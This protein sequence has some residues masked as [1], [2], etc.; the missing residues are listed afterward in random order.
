MP[1]ALAL[2]TLSAALAFEPAPKDLS[3]ETPQKD[4]SEDQLPAPEGPQELPEPDLE[5]ERPAAATASTAEPPVSERAHFVFANYYGLTV[6]VSPLPSFDQVLFLGR[7]FASKA[8]GARRLALGYSLTLS[9]GGADRYTSGIIATRHHITAKLYGGRRERLM[10][11]IG[12]GLALH[13]IIAPSVAEAEARIGYLF[14]GRLQRRRAGVIGLSARLG[15]NFRQREY[16]PMPQI[17]AF[18]GLLLR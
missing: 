8:P 7:A 9:L 17:G 4:P 5:P 3:Q 6:G 16:A 1:N 11:A 15:W 10:L 14:G 18:I 13:A 12:G 2:A